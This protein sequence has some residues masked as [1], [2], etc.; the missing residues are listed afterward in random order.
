MTSGRRL[1]GVLATGVVLLAAV[2][3]TPVAQ[4]GQPTDKRVLDGKVIVIDPGHQLGNSNPK[5]A[6][7]MAQT[8]FN[9]K[10]VKGCN[11]TGT[12]TNAG[13]P[14]A[15]FTWKVAQQL[16]P[17]L[18]RAGARVELTR[19]SNSRNAWGPC[20]WTR[21]ALANRLNADAMISIHA[22]GSSSGNKGFFAMAPARI[23]GWTD[24]VVKVDRQLSKAMID[25][26]AA[27]GAPRSNY[28]AGQLMISSITTTLNL[29]N[30]PT[31]TIEVGN[32]RNA[33]DARRMSTAEG[34]RDYARWLFAG[35]Q[36]FFATR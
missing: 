18:E 21:A 33:Q 13:L 27:A 23:K 28:V 25:G 20:V 6:R 14:E 1:A 16:V 4:A 29:S 10:I 15:T 5:F 26:M 19:T 32:M 12:A 30:V 24:D 9:G 31:T 17:M 7:Q 34:Q 2:I 8:K 22:D 11:T 3:A 35:I 36:R